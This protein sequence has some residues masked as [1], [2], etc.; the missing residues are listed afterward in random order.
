[1]CCVLPAKLA[2]SRVRPAG[3]E[4]ATRGLEVRIGMFVA[5]CQC[6][7]IALSERIS[8]ACR[9]SL[10]AGVCPGHCQVTVKQL[11]DQNFSNAS[12]KSPSCAEEI[13]TLA[14]GAG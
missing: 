13:G 6:S 4:P 3:F 9:S 11:S 7:A 8:Q 5:V 10:F 12:E 14:I 2:F 1:M